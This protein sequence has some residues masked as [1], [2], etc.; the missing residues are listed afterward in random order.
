M[1]A[2]VDEWRDRLE[3][4][5]SP[6]TDAHAQAMTALL[7][8]D[9]PRAV[10]AYD[11]LLARAPNDLQI[12]LG[13]AAALSGAGRF[14]D[15]EPIY[16]NLLREE[17]GSAAIRFDMGVAQ[18]RAGHHDAAERTFAQ[19][20]EIEPRHN[21][22]RFNLAIVQSLNKKP[23]AALEHWRVLTADSHA[24]DVAAWF[25]RGSCALSVHQYA[26]AIVC[27]DNVI[28]SSPR[29]VRAWTN[30]AI[31]RAGD[32]QRDAALAAID[33]ALDIDPR[34]VPALNQAAFVHAAIFRDTELQQHGEAVIGYCN[35]SLALEA[36]Q[37]NIRGLR[38]ALQRLGEQIPETEAR[39]EDVGEP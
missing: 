13:K 5:L 17:P 18:L 11:R 20:L 21:K 3:Q 2:A 19:V 16:E 8:K 30:L 26:D 1:E 27:F 7:E 35:R 39:P 23:L 4:R 14:E 25:H 10:R 31:A 28:A 6:K 32:G 22:A 36:G 24:G 9:Y 12:R 37:M 34:F 29:D 15:A 38:D 33:T